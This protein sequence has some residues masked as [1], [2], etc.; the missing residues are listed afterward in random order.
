MAGVATPGFLR[1]E[2]SEIPLGK[3]SNPA[4]RFAHP[5]SDQPPPRSIHGM[6][7][8][9]FFYG[10][11]MS[12]FCVRV[13]PGSIWP[14]VCRL[15]LYPSRSS[16]TLNLPRRRARPGRPGPRRSPPLLSPETS[17]KPSI[18]EGYS[19]EARTSLYRSGTPVSLNDGG[20]ARRVYFYNARLMARRALSRATP[21]VSRSEE[22][23]PGRPPGIPDGVVIEK[24]SVHRSPTWVTFRPER[25]RF[26]F[27]FVAVAPVA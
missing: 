24:P 15:R 16:S 13:A 18:F 17:C 1:P 21:G 8:L 7:D 14:R 9:V 12:G 20:V 11:L 4:R 2:I 6:T 23:W 22:G 5:S 10:T 26:L 27:H 3:K 25:S 19:Q